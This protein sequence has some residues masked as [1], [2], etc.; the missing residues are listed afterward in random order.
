MLMIRGSR[1]I[2]PESGLDRVTDI[3]ADE[4]GILKLGDM[5]GE[6]IPEKAF[7]ID[8]TGLI[9]GPGLVD[10]HVHFRDPGLTYK[11]DISTGAAAA[12]AGG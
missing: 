2:D 10:V 12:A 5:A 11:E 6:D 4:T 1:V 8:G 9:T 3:L 7:V